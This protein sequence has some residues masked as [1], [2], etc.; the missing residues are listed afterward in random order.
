MFRRPAFATREH[1]KSMPVLLDY[2]STPEHQRQ[3]RFP[4]GAVVLVA[5]VGLGVL[6]FRPLV[7]LLMM[8]ALS[9]TSKAV[10]PAEATQCVAECLMRWG[11]LGAVS[12]RDPDY[13]DLK[14]SIARRMTGIKGYTE[15]DGVHGDGTDWYEIELSPD[16]AAD[17][18]SAMAQS[19]VVKK[20]KYFPREN[21]APSWWPKTWP[22]DAQCYEKDLQYFVLPDNGTRAWF[23]RI[24]T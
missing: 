20:S 14:D 22:R 9:G 19:S 1:R 4:T 10:P 2:Q 15:S 18:R 11:V 16:L 23:L 13:T 6:L 21:S 7:G 24:R 3:Y 8:V 5:L 12:P 17:L